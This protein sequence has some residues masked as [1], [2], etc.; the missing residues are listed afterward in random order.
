MYLG[1]G[2][3]CGT[4]DTKI[5]ASKKW[6]LQIKCTELGS[7]LQ[8]CTLTE[9][10]PTTSWCTSTNQTQVPFKPRLAPLVT[11]MLA[12]ICCCFLLRLSAL[13][14]FPQSPTTL[15]AWGSFCK[16]QLLEQN[17]PSKGH[18]PHVP[19]T[20][21]L[22]WGLARNSLNLQQKPILFR[23]GRKARSTRIA[24]PSAAGVFGGWLI[25]RA[26]SHWDEAV[27]DG[28]RPERV[29]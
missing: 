8:K 29:L 14:S 4:G 7:G 10:L 19:E 5:T 12:N 2:K 6:C 16:N 22:K 23:A 20:G 9:V 11:A 17:C 27:T 21:K 18:H 26:R 15:L 24:R 13:L 1:L 28:T 25:S 3:D